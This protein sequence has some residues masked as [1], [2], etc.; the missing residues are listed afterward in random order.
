MSSV[1]H[2]LHGRPCLSDLHADITLGRARSRHREICIWKIA[3]P[4]SVQPILL[5]GVRHARTYV[6]RCIG[7]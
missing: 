3:L 5:S 6:D 7:V 2:A 1:V 4:R